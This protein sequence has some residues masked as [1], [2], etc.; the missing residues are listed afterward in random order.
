MPDDFSLAR[1]WDLVDQ[2]STTAPVEVD[3]TD[4]GLDFK[5][6]FGDVVYTIYIAGTERSSP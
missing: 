3:E 4:H 2:L 5:N 6:Y 1:T